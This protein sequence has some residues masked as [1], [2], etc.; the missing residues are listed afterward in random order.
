M[1]WQILRPCTSEYVLL[2]EISWLRS[3]S[4]RVPPSTNS[5]TRKRVPKRESSVEESSDPKP[6]NDA[7]FG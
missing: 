1:S 6:M 4:F 5:C 2:A 3:R 7:I